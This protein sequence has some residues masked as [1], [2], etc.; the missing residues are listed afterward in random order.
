[1]TSE[2]HRI[3]GIDTF[4]LLND[5]S[6]DDSGCFLGEYV[7]Q[8]FVKSLSRELGQGMV[9]DE[10]ARLIRE[11]ASFDDDNTWMVT[12]DVDE[13]LWFNETKYSSLKDA[14]LDLSGRN[15]GQVKS[16]KVPRLLFGASGQDRQE[17]GPM[18][19]RFTQRLDPSG[20]PPESPRNNGKTMHVPHTAIRGFKSMSVVSAI[21]TDCFVWKQKKNETIK[22]K[23]RCSTTHD[24][25][26]ALPSLSPNELS[27]TQE[28]TNKYSGPLVLEGKD[29]LD[30]LVIAHYQTKSRE[31]FYQRM[32]SS[33]FAGKYSKCEGCTPATAFDD[34][35]SYAN[36]YKDTRMLQ[37]LDPLEKR[38]NAS[39][40]LFSQCDGQPKPRRPLDSYADCWSQDGA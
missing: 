7:K 11:D 22:K 28:F 10:C 39:D 13:F 32:C 33:Q 31:E 4:F 12:H 1:M 2:F 19:A 30:S 25:T 37:Y 15:D 21:A 8:K 34:Y 18:I 20:P 36:N 23:T 14:V 24:H 26:L 6:T 9:F 35:Q 38:L 5:Q 40:A 29:T 16:I 17:P 27:E 3:L